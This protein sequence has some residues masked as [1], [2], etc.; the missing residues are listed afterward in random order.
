MEEAVGTTVASLPVHVVSRRFSSASVLQCF[1]VPLL[2]GFLH[3]VSNHRCGER[4]F[5]GLFDSVSAFY[6]YL[7]IWTVILND[8]AFHS[9]LSV[10]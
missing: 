5:S 8:Y 6:F 7:E 10:P 9:V 3:R 1:P 4:G 2:A